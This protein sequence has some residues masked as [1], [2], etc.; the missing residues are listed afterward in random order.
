[1]RM[2]GSIQVLYWIEYGYILF[3]PCENCHCSFSDSFFFSVCFCFNVQIL[4]KCFCQ[5]W[6]LYIVVLICQT[7]H[8]CVFPSNNNTRLMAQLWL[9]Y[10]LFLSV[11]KKNMSFFRISKPPSGS[12]HEL[13]R[14]QKH[15]NHQSPNPA[16]SA[17]WRHHDNPLPHIAVPYNR[18]NEEQHLQRKN[19]PLSNRIPGEG[20]Y[21]IYPLFLKGTF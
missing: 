13:K 8:A 15:L 1:M 20:K 11:P 9:T 17:I 19:N 21:I 4:F 6:Q 12:N 7:F 16:V 3:E 18:C 14:L 10:S 2:S 5:L